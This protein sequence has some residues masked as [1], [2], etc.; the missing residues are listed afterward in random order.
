MLKSGFYFSYSLNITLPLRLQKEDRIAR[1]FAWNIRFLEE[2]DVAKVSRI[3]QCPIIQGFARSF[4]VYMEGAK[5]GYVL[6]SR[7]SNKKGGTRYF[8]RGVDDDG[9]VANFCETEQ[10]IRLGEYTM[11][12]LQI[13]GSIPIFFEQVGLTTTMKLNRG[14]EL[15]H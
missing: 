10:I 8:D 12:D 3:W 11:S 1:R 9:Y 2:L 14:F 7:R 4:E 15:T 13:R 6:V 5:L